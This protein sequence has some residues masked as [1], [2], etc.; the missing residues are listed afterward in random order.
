MGMLNFLLG[1][2]FSGFGFKAN[3]PE[4]RFHCGLMERQGYAPN[5]NRGNGNSGYRFGKN[6][7]RAG[8]GW[9]N[10]LAKDLY[11]FD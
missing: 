7:G 10:S 11:R 5:N 6:G 9:E 2:L 3:T 4:L 8:Y 1:R